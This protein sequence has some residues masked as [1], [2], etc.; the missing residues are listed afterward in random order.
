MNGLAPEAS[1]STLIGARFS[2]AVCCGA[3]AGRSGTPGRCAAC[4]VLVL[5]VRQHD[6]PSIQVRFQQLG[7]GLKES[8]ESL[9]V[10]G[11]PGLVTWL[12]AS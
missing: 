5:R 8:E 12:A 2:P 1:D 10:A 4:S 11:P 6:K 3:S 7:R 9:C